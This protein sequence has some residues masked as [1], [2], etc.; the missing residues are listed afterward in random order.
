MSMFLKVRLYVMSNNKKRKLILITLVASIAISYFLGQM[1]PTPDKNITERKSP[2]VS[3][4]TLKKENIKI[5]I[6]SQGMVTPLIE[7]ILS[8]EV[9]G[10]IVEI[11]P[12]FLAGGVFKEGEILMRIDPTIYIVAL[13]QAKALKDQRQNEYEDAEKIRKQG[14]LSESEYLSSVTALAAA[15]AELVKSQRNLDRTKIVLPYDGMVRDKSADLGQYVNIGKQLGTVFATD[16]AE[17]RLPLSDKDV[18]FADL[19]SSQQTFLSDDVTGPEVEFTDDQS[20]STNKRYGYIAR[21]EGVIDEKTRMTYA[22]ARLEDPYNLKGKDGIT[23]LPIGSFVSAKIYPTK[24]YKFIKIPRSAIINNR[25]VI[26]INDSNQ[27]YFQNIELIRTD[28]DFGYIAEGI[29]DGQRISIT[30]I[31]DGINGMKVRVDQ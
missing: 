9:S 19:P 21:S 11:S 8:A 6:D 12:K 25:Q 1:K 7:T 27:I 5:S 10:T 17:V 24:E 30:S 22:V 13:D 2:I 14:F 3:S 18:L 20:N 26:L 28:K 31:E 29:E 23:A 4:I 16:V 15:E